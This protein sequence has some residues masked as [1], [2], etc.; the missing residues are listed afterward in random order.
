VLHQLEIIQYIKGTCIPY[1]YIFNIDKISIQKY[2]K[3]HYKK[4][5]H[6]YSEWADMIED[7]ARRLDEFIK[8]LFSDSYNNVVFDFEITK[9]IAFAVKTIFLYYNKMKKHQ[10]LLKRDIEK[11]TIQ[12]HKAIMREIS[13]QW[14]FN[15]FRLYHFYFPY[16]IENQIQAMRY[17]ITKCLTY[18]GIKDQLNFDMPKLD[19]KTFDSMTFDRDWIIKKEEKFYITYK[20]NNFINY[21]N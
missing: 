4:E 20:N 15:D 1:L 7:D 6:N 16:Q 19:A 18:F 3:S 17:Y 8:Y 11:E 2:I 10:I 14:K 21:K 5:T 9:S 12:T 13:K